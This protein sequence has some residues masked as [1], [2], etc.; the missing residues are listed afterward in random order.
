MKSSNPCVIGAPEGERGEVI[1]AKNFL[2]PVKI[3][4]HRFKNP[5]KP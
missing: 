1:M 5:C 4:S 2:K 3:A